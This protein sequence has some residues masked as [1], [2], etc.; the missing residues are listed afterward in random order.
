MVPRLGRSVAG[1]RHRAV[2][3]DQ[4]FPDGYQGALFT[5]HGLFSHV[6]QTGP[7]LFTPLPACGVLAP[8]RSWL[9]DASRIPRCSSR[10]LLVPE[11]PAPI[12][13]SVRSAI[14]TGYCGK[15]QSEA[16]HSVTVQSDS[17]MQ[18]RMLSPGCV[19]FTIWS[20]RQSVVINQVHVHRLSLDKAEDNAPA[21][22]ETRTLH[23]LRRSP[24]SGCSRS[25]GSS[26]SWADCAAARSVKIRRIRRVKCCGTRR[27]SFRSAGRCSPLCTHRVQR[28]M[29]VAEARCVANLA[30]SSRLPNGALRSSGRLVSFT[31]KSLC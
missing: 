2:Q 24:F 8:S 13:R 25:P 31:L 17:L 30:A 1:R 7:L 29:S 23:C 11:Q 27:A 22:P 3:I 19:G 10:R 28:S 6:P 16:A 9:A 14:E 12:S 5:L 18:L 21:I 20:L 15:R 4:G 26:M